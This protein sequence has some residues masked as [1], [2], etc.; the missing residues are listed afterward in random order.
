MA[1]PLVHY[2]SSG[3]G[4][5]LVYWL[6]SRV[7]RITTASDGRPGSGARLMDYTPLL[8]ALLAALLTHVFVDSI[9]PNWHLIPSDWYLP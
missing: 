5:L 4:A 8:L 1:G 3:A 6:T 7:L 9:A 2:L